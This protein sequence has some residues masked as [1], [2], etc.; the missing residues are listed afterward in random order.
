MRH[1][2]G[3]KKEDDDFNYTRDNTLLTW[4]GNGCKHGVF[5][6]QSSL[7]QFTEV[8]VNMYGYSSSPAPSNEQLVKVTAQGSNSER[9]L[10]F[11]AVLSYSKL[12]FY[13]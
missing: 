6:T 11:I 13:L 7:I 8:Y 5:V 4:I 1:G 10:V 2:F 12:C 9:Y 3:G